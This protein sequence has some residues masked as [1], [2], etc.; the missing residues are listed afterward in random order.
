MPAPLATFITELRRR[1]VFRVAAFYGGVAFVLFQIIDSIFEPLHIPEWIGSLIIILLL[2][3]F[4]VAI[5][6]AWI[7]DITP[8]GIVRTEGRPTGKPGTSNKA[9]IAIAVAAI[10][11][12]IWGRWGGQGGSYAPIRSIAVIPLDNLMNDPDQQYF[13]DGMQEALTAEL[14]RIGALRVIGRS[15][16]KRYR[17]DLKSIPEMAEELNV[18]AVVEGSLLRDG[19]RVLITVQL[20]ATKPERHLWTNS[21]ER[22]LRDILKLISEVS[23]DIARQ[24]K[25]VLTPAE[26]AR[27]KVAQ[28]TVDPVAYTLYLKG[29]HIMWEGYDAQAAIPFFEKAINAD[30]SYS[31]VYADLAFALLL[32]GETDLTIVELQAR[33]LELIDQAIALDAALP[34]AYVVL[35]YLRTGQGKWQEAGEAFHKALALAPNSRE[36][37]VEF[38]WFL[39]RTGNVDQAVEQMELSMQ[40]DPLSIHSHHSLASA[41]YYQGQYD[42]ALAVIMSGLTLVPDNSN[43]RN[44]AALI[45]LKLGHYDQAI[46]YF[47]GWDQ[48]SLDLKGLILVSRGQRGEA[49]QLIESIK[50]RPLTDTTGFAFDKL[51]FTYAALGELDLAM[52]QLEHVY[53]IEKKLYN[54]WTY[55]ISF[56]KVNPSYDPLRGHPRFEA[57]LK[58]LYSE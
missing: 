27:L 17:T 3:G 6:L 43:A 14:S 33:S 44:T 56:L 7:F 16:T 41:L 36:A 52:D 5:G 32:S 21:Y 46:N 45:H 40:L 12:G 57:F 19:D 15:S 25:I 47:G 30:P 55:G 26:V 54:L 1:R 18:D 23:R 28:Q 9:L 50:S 8:V 34:G 58:D 24:I 49:R 22:D 20:V 51:I 53:A 2:V 38:G 13:V 35:G 31:Y 4:P 37:N 48:V 29:R 42:S 10:A 11:F 39:I